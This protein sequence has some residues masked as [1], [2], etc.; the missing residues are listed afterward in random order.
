[1]ETLE[2]TNNKAQENLLDEIK[3][4]QLSLPN[5][6]WFVWPM[7]LYQGLWCLSY[8]LEGI[9]SFKTHFQ[10]HDTDII[11][12]SLPKTGTTWLKSLI[13][14]I[15]NRTKFSDDFTQHPL[16]TKNP[17]ALIEHLEI[18][19]YKEVNGNKPDLSEI[20]SPRLFATH[21]SYLSLPDSIKNSKCRIVYVCRN[22]FDTFVSIWHFF[23]EFEPCKGIKP[24]LVMMEK[25]V[26]KFCSGVSPWGPYED[27]VLGYWKES[28]KNQQKVIFLE[29]EG[30][31]KEPEAHLKRLAEFL[32]YPF[33]EVEEKNNVINK[34]VELCSLKSLKE[35][36]VNK[37]GRLSTKFENKILLRKG[38]VGDWNKY[39]TPT[40][41]KRIEEMQEK[42]KKAGFSSSYYQTNLITS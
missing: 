32:G 39:L 10:A 19:V 42:L 30:L 9:I 35:M 11:L 13:F 21:V 5:E 15:V 16:R 33:S 31:K 27:H 40:L 14:A 22:P 12:A 1:M 18:N 23:L 24:D 29:Y 34:I 3:E 20:P 8:I 36:E 2:L 6:T 17:H 25:Y 38:E 28:K 41:A 26:D 7:Y 4:L 37:I